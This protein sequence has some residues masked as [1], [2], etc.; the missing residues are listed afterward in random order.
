MSTPPDF[1]VTL[2]TGASS[3]IGLALAERLARRS[4]TLILVARREE[5]LVQLAE[6]LRIESPS[7]RVEVEVCDLSEVDAVERLGREALSRHGAVDLLVNNAGLG[8]IGLFEV[9]DARKNLSMMQVN[10][11][12][13]TMLTR[14]LL[15]AMIERGRGAIL[16]ISSGFGLVWMPGAAAYVGTKHYMT[17]WSDSLRCELTGTGVR[18]TQVCPGPVATEFEAV[19]GNPTGQEV[20]GFILLDAAACASSALAA[21]DRGQA[22]VVPGFWAWVGISLGQLCPRWLLRAQWSLLGALARRRLPHVR[23]TAASVDSGAENRT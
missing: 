10:V 9:S 16:N 17:A 20:P 3:G 5:R 15:P 4:G 11:V 1:S 23:A 2:L 18:V 14:L 13:P 12:A 6:R 22:L 7:C 19:A 21:L 8:D